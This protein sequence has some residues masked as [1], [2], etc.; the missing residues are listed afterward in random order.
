MKKAEKQSSGKAHAIQDRSIGDRF[1]SVIIYVVF[2]AF[3]FICAYPF[4]YIFI[5]SISDNTL[6]EKGA[7]ILYP[8]G[9]HLK[10]YTDAFAIPG[11][12]NAAMVSVA[13]TVLGTLL[14][15]FTSAF[16]GYM[17][18]RSTLWKRKF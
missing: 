6:S 3:A 4:Y 5:N 10:N 15:L 1:M 11:L 9:V 12:M 14:V 8:M 7:V 13:R 16:L 18:T 2:G 17:F